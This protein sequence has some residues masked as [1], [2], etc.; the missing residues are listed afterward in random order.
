MIN[1]II[2]IFFQLYTLGFLNIQQIFITNLLLLIIF[3]GIFSISYY[4]NYYK[5]YKRELKEE[6]RLYNKN[7][8]IYFSLKQLSIILFGMIWFPITICICF[9][10]LMVSGNYW[11]QS[12]NRKP[13]LKVLNYLG[14]LTT[15]LAPLI[16]IIWFLLIELDY[17]SIAA[18]GLSLF[19]YLNYGLKT[20]SLSLSNLIEKY[21][22]RSS[23]KF[24][25]IV[26]AAVLV[27]L[28]GIP[29]TILT[30]SAVYAP[31]EK[32]TYMVEMRDGVRLATDVYIA[33]GS[34][35]TPKPVILIRTPYGKNGMDTYRT[36]YSTQDYH[37][38]IQDLR[39]THD[40]EGGND[41]LLFTSDYQD[42][43][44]II[45]WILA[46][47]WCNGKIASSGPSALAIN[48]YFYAGM[49]PQGLVAQ[50]LWFGTPELYDHAIYQG[51]YHKS[52]VE[53]WIESTAPDNWRYQIETLFTYSSPQNAVLYNSTSLSYPIGP[54]YSNISV[55]AI[56]VGGWYDHFLQGTIDGFINYDDNSAIA[57]QGKQKLIIGPWTHVNLFDSTKQGELTYPKNSRG[58]DLAFAWEQSVFDYALLGK[59]TDW[60]KERV[61]YYLMGDVDTHSDEWN[62]WRYAYDWPLDHVDDKWYFTSTGALIN[63]T[64]PSINKS[65]SYLYDPRDPVPTLGG[66]NQPFDPNGPMDQRSIE[67][68][69]DVLI[70]ETPTLTESVEIVGRI[71]GNLSIT[72]NCTDTDFTLKLTDVYPDGRSMLITDGSLTTRSRF[73]YTSNVFMSGNQNDVYELLIDLWTTAYVFAPGHKIRVAIS[74]S[75][76][77]RFAAN[78]NT[79]ATLAFNYLNY[80]IAN[81][82]VLIGPDYPSYIILPRLV[83]MSSTH[84]SF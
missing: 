75:N 74:S 77:P 80:N 25:K 24:P 26:K 42:G 70:F 54:H 38:V 61:A 48:Q 76:Y 37:L 6:R 34:F 12:G 7:E 67:N 40:S 82:T 13:K 31:P 9:Y 30:F 60:N 39:G 41:F 58:F 65:F 57:A 55:A 14:R 51:S 59:S 33:P 78:P 45:N 8:A 56:H 50:Q 22:K 46:Q 63:S 44:D 4:F 16:G 29:S 73:N 62:Y 3:R 84:T 43:V 17:Y 11:K 72:S 10:S 32:L 15:F 52:S 69:N 27:L 71:L 19:F 20:S 1:W 49:G 21:G 53:Q 23:L 83:N 66:Q 81:N 2:M 5:D 18:V 64:L 47:N 35:N 68:R 36:F 79:G 28:I